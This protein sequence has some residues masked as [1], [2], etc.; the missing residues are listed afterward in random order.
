VHPLRTYTKSR[1]GTAPAVGGRR[2]VETIAH[3]PP[4]AARG[5]S[6]GK[7]NKGRGG[8]G[9]QPKG[10]AGKTRTAVRRQTSPFQVRTEVRSGSDQLAVYEGKGQDS[11]DEP[12]EILRCPRWQSG[13]RKRPRR[14]GR[15]GG[16]K[17]RVPCKPRRSRPGHKSQPAGPP[18]PYPYNSDAEVRLGPSPTAYLPTHQ[19]PH[20]RWR[21]AGEGGARGRA[22][23]LSVWQPPD[24]GTGSVRGPYVRE[25]VTRNATKGQMP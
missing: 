11:R 24:Q 4:L 19:P 9:A 25:T 3:Q 16:K 17:G 5:D 8:E 18:K 15:G 10:R 13:R 20:P 7:G 14:Q 6:Q 23:A 22:E 21:G 1:E 2:A 12:A